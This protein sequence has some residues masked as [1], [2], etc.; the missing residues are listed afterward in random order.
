MSEDTKQTKGLRMEAQAVEMSRL[1]QS[2]L[3]AAAEIVEKLYSAYHQKQPKRARDQRRNQL[4]MVSGDKGSGK[5][6]LALSIRRWYDL[7][8]NTS[9]EINL[10]K[11]QFDEV[12]PGE[13]TSYEKI[14]T[15]LDEL[16]EDCRRITWLD[17]LSLDTMPPGTNL[18]AAIFAR[19]T[20][21]AARQTDPNSPFRQ[22]RG[23]LEPVSLFERA[24]HELGSLRSDA[25]MAL[26]GNLHRRAE[27]MD[28]ESYAI[29]AI[30]NE[31]KKLEVP[32]RLNNV[33]RRLVERAT[34]RGEDEVKGMF[35][36]PIDDIDSSP[37]RAAEMLKLAYS[38]S[39]PRL[40]FLLLGSIETIDQILFYQIQGEFRGLL[41]AEGEEDA[42]AVERVTAK[43]NEIASSS[44]RKMIPPSQRIALEPL[45]LEHAARFKPEISLDSSRR[46]SL[47][48][49]SLEEILKEINFEP[50]VFHT[51]A[52]F[53]RA[54][55]LKHLLLARDPFLTK[56]DEKPER[57]SHEPS[58]NAKQAATV[59]ADPSDY[60]YD[61]FRL[62]QSA[63]RQ[64]AD[65]YGLL[66]EHKDNK[67]HCALIHGLFTETFRPL[68]DEDGSLTPPVQN[69]LKECL[70][71]D[72]FSNEAE[73]TPPFL[74][75][76]TKTGDCLEFDLVPFGID[77]MGSLHPACRVSGRRV[78]SLELESTLP[79]G[80]PRKFGTSTRSAFKFIHDL[81]RFTGRGVITHTIP[82]RDRD[83]IACTRWDD[84]I[85][86][87]FDVPWLMCDWLTFWHTD[88]FFRLWNRGLQRTRQVC[89]EPSKLHEEGLSHLMIVIAA[90]ALVATAKSQILKDDE[91]LDQGWE[92]D[93][94][95]LL[96]P[97]KLE[98]GS[99]PEWTDDVL[100]LDNATKKIATAAEDLAEKAR[101]R[102]NDGKDDDQTEQINRALINLTLLL[103]PECGIAD[104]NNKLPGY[105]TLFLE[106]GHV[107]NYLAPQIRKLRLK[108]L[109]I[110]ASTLL[111]VTLLNPT[112]TL[113]IAKSSTITKLNPGISSIA[114]RIKTS[115]PLFF[116]G[117]AYSPS[118]QDLR[119]AFL[120]AER[121]RAT[122]PLHAS[123]LD[124]L[125]SHF[126]VDGEKNPKT[127][128]KPK[129]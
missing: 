65:L 68:V 106:H 37:A 10:G 110:H 115:H 4:L 83:Q 127:S 128:R 90:A 66:V 24:L 53:S 7:K 33:L 9:T 129:S 1:S 26:E 84:G 52:D 36:L 17:A 48:S 76:V 67:D 56:P 63:P 45:T 101:I 70:Q 125:R 31:K 39:I 2:Q 119:H 107:K 72:P 22:D 116:K 104:K 8:S 18:V 111:G 85:N 73:L 29:A 71:P 99:E 47:N 123:E 75:M 79:G 108:R 16:I 82:H 14:G 64:L 78:R 102:T 94:V 93:L 91:W 126:G 57:E 113:T 42:D 96:S 60:F 121:M 19:I 21:A 120:R 86:I 51:P 20:E 117:S 49:S 61:G 35:V 88:L 118:H 109:K 13:R 77:D 46:E 114:E 12:A 100:G 27:G 28:P 92:N 89:R 40:V 11:L 95:A 30:E 58:E 59:S 5:T 62:L 15:K 54:T 6:T 103:T 43:A 34:T 69:A 122:R 98:P 55:N 80:K 50:K 112:E 87:Y 74:S 81:I 3:K 23:L 41:R 44:L 32:D 124:L 97:R 105:F 25:V 38:L